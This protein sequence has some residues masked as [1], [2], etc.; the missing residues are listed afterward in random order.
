MLVALLILSALGAATLIL[1]P[2][3]IGRRGRDHRSGHRTW[4]F[5]YFGL[6]GIGFL[7]VEIPLIQ[8]Y[9]SISSYS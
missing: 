3:V 8:Q 2:L 9:R 1:A 7:F 6:L 5:G 4:T